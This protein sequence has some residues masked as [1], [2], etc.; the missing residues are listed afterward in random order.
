MVLILEEIQS[1]LSFQSLDFGNREKADSF[2]LYIHFPP[3]EN[4]SGMADLNAVSASNSWVLLTI[5]LI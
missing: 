3:S 5:S 4:K 1:Q 2:F